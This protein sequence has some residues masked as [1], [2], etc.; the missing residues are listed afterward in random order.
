VASNLK[1]LAWKLESFTGPVNDDISL[2]GSSAAGFG[3]NIGEFKSMGCNL[4]SGG[5]STST[6]PEGKFLTGEFT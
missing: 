3:N 2:N 4:K 6:G 1:G 5:I